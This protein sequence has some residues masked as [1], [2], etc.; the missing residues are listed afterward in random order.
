MKTRLSREHGGVL[1]L[2]LSLTIILGT[3]LASYL[4]LVEYQNRSVV[5][6]QFWNSSIPAAEAGIE[7]ALAHLNQLGDND[8]ATNGWTLVTNVYKMTRT[9]GNSRYDVT[10]DT[11]LQPTITSV[12]YV[13]DPMTGKEIK[14]TVQVQTTRFGAG[15]RGIIT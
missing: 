9:L 10:I 2:T 12:G 11:L 15:M 13:T 6:S 7:E 5:R 3:A 1:L 8:R 14:R 4:K